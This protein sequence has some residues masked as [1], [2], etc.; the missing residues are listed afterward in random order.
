MGPG[1]GDG[2]E[3]HLGPQRAAA[4]S[5]REIAGHR[6]ARK[7]GG[8]GRGGVLWGF[9]WG[10]SGSG[11]WWPRAVLA[12]P[13]PPLPPFLPSSLP[14]LLQRPLLLRHRPHR[15][16]RP[17]LAHLPR[18]AHHRL[19]HVRRRRAGRHCGAAPGQGQPSALEPR[20]EL[21]GQHRHVWR[22]AEHEPGAGVP[23]LPAGL[24]GVRH[25]RYGRHRCV[26]VSCPPARHRPA[27]PRCAAEPLPAGPSPPVRWCRLPCGLF[28]AACTPWPSPPSCLP[29][30]HVLPPPA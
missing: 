27:P 15:R 19:P 7:G 24:P 13:E 11:Q 9:W 26:V 30:A 22:R 25:A 8:A 2:H 21:G 12:E 14:C 4:V 6:M 17:L 23:L 18:G 10:A 20:E 16:H 1:D 3:P 5:E 29:P 28:K